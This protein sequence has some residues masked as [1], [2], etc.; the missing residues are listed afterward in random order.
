MKNFDLNVGGLIGALLF[1]GIAG[2][3]VFT[4]IDVEKAGRGAYRFP[5]IALIVGAVVGNFLWGLV[6]NKDK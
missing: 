1:G 4:N 3:L 6:F 2:A 5:I